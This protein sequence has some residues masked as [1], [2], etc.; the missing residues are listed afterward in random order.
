MGE[1]VLEYLVKST[2]DGTGAKASSAA[3]KQV[4]KDA[5]DADAALRGIETQWNRR[6]DE[7]GRRKK[8]I[9]ELGASAGGDRNWMLGFKEAATGHEELSKKVEKSTLKGKEFKKL[10]QLIGHE[11]PVAGLA[12]RAAFSP[13]GATLLAAIA[14]FKMVMEHVKRLEDAAN[15]SD[16]S[17]MTRQTEMIRQ[18]MVESAVATANFE[19]EMKRLGDQSDST[20]QKL[21]R[22]QKIHEALQAAQEKLDDARKRLELAQSGNIKDPVERA[23]KKL[24]IEER[25]AAKE[26]ARHDEETRFQLSEKY[27][28]LRGSESAASTIAKLELPGL[29]AAAARERT[30]EVLKAQLTE[31][32][33]ALKT[34]KADLKAKETELEKVEKDVASR[35]IIPPLFAIDEQYGLEDAIVPLKNGVQQLEKLV[36][37]L[38]A[39]MP[40]KLSSYNA[41]QEAVKAAEARQRAEETTANSLRREIETDKTVSDIEIKG[42]AAVAPIES[43][44]R[45]QEAIKTMSEGKVG[46]VIVAGAEALSTQAAGQKLTA[47]GEAKVTALKNLLAITGENNAKELALLQSLTT[48]ALGM[49]DEI[50][51]LSNELAEACKN[52]RNN[53]RLNRP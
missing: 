19:R 53:A 38:E 43:A 23:R 5:K 8:M 12:L 22:Q 7:M 40:A 46:E 28:L 17:A 15:T 47:D 10:M 37:K 29:R 35:V 42:R 21:E 4:V 18:A 24:E 41:A 27:R 48:N 14:A 20:S 26:K 16:W 30:P 49:A 50:I 2:F 3:M 33:E 45:G 1:E 6:V 36:K 11:A 39:E 51:R 31:A 13:V 32:Q 52:N 25:Y 34:V 44:I 9:G